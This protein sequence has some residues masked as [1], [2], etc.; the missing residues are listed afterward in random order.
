MCLVHFVSTRSFG[1]SSGEDMDFALSVR[2]FLST[3]RMCNANSQKHCGIILFTD[4]RIVEV[5][6]IIRV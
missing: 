2:R 5:L 4:L 1:F 6:I 3:R